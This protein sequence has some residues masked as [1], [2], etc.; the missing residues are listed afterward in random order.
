MC[1]ELKPG[2]GKG[3]L[4][5]FRRESQRVTATTRT[6]TAKKLTA[7]AVRA[8][9]LLAQSTVAQDKA[10]TDLVSLLLNEN[11]APV[12]PTVPV[13]LAKALV[14]VPTNNKQSHGYPVG[15]P[16]LLYKSNKQKALYLDKGKLVKGENLPFTDNSYLRPATEKEVEA[17]YKAASVKEHFVNNEAVLGEYVP[18]Q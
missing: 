10:M 7:R 4:E 1:G 9:A 3:S 12:Q 15:K 2:E 17:F 5:F 13:S 18:A 6:R 16:V 14:L 8:Q 11:I